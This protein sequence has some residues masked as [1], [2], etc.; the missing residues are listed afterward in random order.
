MKSLLDERPEGSTVLWSIGGR[1][2]LGLTGWVR[3]DVRSMDSSWISTG[4]CSSCD[5]RSGVTACDGLCSNNAVSVSP[6]T[7]GCPSASGAS[8]ACCSVLQQHQNSSLTLEFQA[9]FNDHYN[10]DFNTLFANLPPLRKYFAAGVPGSFHGRLFP[11]STL[12]FAHCSYALHWL[13]KIPREIMDNTSPAWNKDSIQCTGIV[14]EVAEAYLA[15]YKNDMESFF[16]ARAQELVAGGLMVILLSVRPNGIPMFMTGEGKVYDL[17]GTCLVDL[18]KKG[19]LSEEKVNSFNLPIYYPTMKELED[20]VQ[21]NGYFTIERMNKLSI[22]MTQMTFSPQLICS[23][24]RSVFEGVIKE[25]FGEEFIDHI[26][27]HFTTK[28]AENLI[29]FKEK[30]P[31]RTELFILLKRL[32]ID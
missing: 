25:H 20:L 21:N 32:N 19:L 3:C 22:P 29:I 18:A 11:K 27:N 15:Q 24:I 28:L 31:H 12:H 5:E 10:N 23:M 14:K 13:C 17:L 2:S 8:G 30:D 1:R 4:S 6:G 26:F 7:A 16:N 9:I